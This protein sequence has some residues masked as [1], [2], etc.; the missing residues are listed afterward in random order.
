[1]KIKK[2]YVYIAAIVIALTACV[3]SLYYYFFVKLD[4]NWVFWRNNGEKIEWEEIAYDE[5]FTP[6]D[7][8]EYYGQYSEWAFKKIKPVYAGYGSTNDGLNYLIGKYLDENG[9]EKKVYILVSGDGIVDYPYADS[10]VSLEYDEYFKKGI[11][12]RLAGEYPDFS[13]TTFT[14]TDTDEFLNVS[15]EY[16]NECPDF[17]WLTDEQISQYVENGVFSGHYVSQTN[18][19]I[20]CNEYEMFVSMYSNNVSYSFDK[21]VSQ[22]KAGQQFT[23]TYLETDK[24]FDEC[25]YEYSGA[26]KLICAVENLNEVYDT[27]MVA[28]YI[29][30][31]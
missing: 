8:T 12:V 17:V 3:G 22:L 10:D 19:D 13:S 5:D 14:Y 16:T 4:T 23:V 6:E 28:I 27:Y 24:T 15:D 7:E 2:I 1:M 21:L 9:K 30:L 20:Y 18:F 26:E 29:E 25:K 11:L 31:D